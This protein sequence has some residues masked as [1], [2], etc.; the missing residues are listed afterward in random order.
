MSHISKI[1]TELKWL[2]IQHNTTPRYIVLTQETYLEML[3]TLSVGSFG[4]TDIV[5]SN[6]F[7]GV[8]VIIRDDIDFDF[9]LV[10]DSDVKQ[11]SINV[12]ISN[13]SDYQAGVEQLMI[14]SKIESAIN[15]L[16]HR[17]YSKSFYL[18]MN[19]RTLKLIRKYW[20]I[21]DY[22]RVVIGVK[23]DFVVEVVGE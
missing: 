12:I 21:D 18:K 22:Y 2:K 11:H 4:M 14:M 10:K 3:K 17:H 9:I 19:S 6:K 8:D 13:I 7:Y 15:D 20:D 23:D 1:L 16:R 5:N